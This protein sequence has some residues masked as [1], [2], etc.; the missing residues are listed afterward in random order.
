MIVYITVCAVIQSSKKQCE[1]NKVI[2]LE[3][4]LLFDLFNKHT[5]LFQESFSLC[6]IHGDDL[7][8]TQNFLNPCCC[9]KRKEN[10]KV[11]RGRRRGVISE[12][13]SPWREENETERGKTQ[14]LPYFMNTFLNYKIE[15]VEV[16]KSSL[17]NMKH[18]LVLLLLIK[19]GGQ[20]D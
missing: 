13:R 9:T 1:E 12:Q 16:I 2:R 18:V 3:C 6:H 20:T 10:R 4:I 8:I 7:K 11:R 5:S 15:M 19:K 17:T 14:D